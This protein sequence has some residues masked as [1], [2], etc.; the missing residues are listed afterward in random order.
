[1]ITLIEK[2]G[3]DKRLI[4]NWRPISLVNVD[5]KIASKSLAIRINEFLPQLIV[6][7]RHMLNEGTLVNQ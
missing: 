2:K 1:M 3:R 7:K 5:T 4:E 6:I